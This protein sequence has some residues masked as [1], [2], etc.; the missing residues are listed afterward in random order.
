MEE[1]EIEDP[2][3]GEEETPD[4]GIVEPGDDEEL[5]T[6][7]GEA[8][9]MDL[10]GYTRRDQEL[11]VATFPD[12]PVTGLLADG[13]E[14]PE[15]VQTETEEE[16]EQ[17]VAPEEE[18]PVIGEPFVPTPG[19]VLT[20]KKDGDTLY[21]DWV[22]ATHEG[23]P[24]ITDGIYGFSLDENGKP[25]ISTKW[26]TDLQEEDPA[27]HQMVYGAYKEALRDYRSGVKDFE[28]QQV[29]ASRQ[30]E[31][32]SAKLDE[33]IQKVTPGL[34]SY[35]TE[36]YKDSPHAEAIADNVV[37]LYPQLLKDFIA[38]NVDAV[39]KSE[40]VSKSQ[41]EKMIR[42]DIPAN[43]HAQLIAEAEKRSLQAALSGKLVTK[44][45]LAVTKANIDRVVPPTKTGGRV[46]S[47]GTTSK[48]ATSTMPAAYR[49][50]MERMG[51]DEEGINNA[52]KNSQAPN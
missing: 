2:S 29:V 45:G 5:E 10:S 47:T 32:R 4:F 41:A 34:K 3:V 36:Q 26:L 22:L 44:S 6:D 23:N 9:P 49:A 39:A 38:Q 16:S 19:T 33:A 50:K 7:T 40:N 51:F 13:D 12:T 17:Q 25:V 27:K 21:G 42:A 30:I 8:K 43:I 1:D 52:W 46:V 28:Q 48:V 14:D 11:F 24:V 18:E 37:T 20:G 15:E 35:M 31:E